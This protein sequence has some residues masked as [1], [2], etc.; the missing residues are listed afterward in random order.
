MLH[1]YYHKYS[2]KQQQ[3]KQLYCEWFLQFKITVLIYSCN[4]KQ[5]SVSHDP[6]EVI[7]ICWFAVQKTFIIIIII[8]VENSLCCL[9][10]S[11]YYNSKHWWIEYIEYNSQKRTKNISINLSIYIYIYKWN[12]KNEKYYKYNTIKIIILLILLTPYFIKVVDITF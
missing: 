10:Y 4:S 3:Q 9:T 6:S 1:L 2:K 5:S 7:L 12:T 8:N 11:E